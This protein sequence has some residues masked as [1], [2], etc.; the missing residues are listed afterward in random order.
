MLY[1][2]WGAYK[3]F[4]LYHLALH[5]ATGRDWLGWK[6]PEPRR[7]LYVD[8]EMSLYTIRLRFHQIARG[9][10][11]EVG[12]WGDKLMVLPRVG[13]HVTETAAPTLIRALGKWGF[14]PDVVILE[15][16]R[17]VMLGDENQAGNVAA[18][19]RNIAPLVNQGWSL[20]VSHHMSK[21]SHE[22]PRALRDRQSGS[23][24]ILAG[25][26]CAI[27]VTRQGNSNSVD[28]HPTKQRV[29]KLA[30]TFTVLVESTGDRWTGPVTVRRDATFKRQ[31]ENPWGPS[32]AAPT[33]PSSSAPR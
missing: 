13:F 11:L 1:G 2:E 18:F 33:T 14:T 30:D 8:E 17:R 28:L 23:T 21:P 25:V 22:Y 7:V 4:L 5:L 24:D 9:M 3:S 20:Y 32:T 27:A 10:G 12:E 16:L 15:A 6:I 19:W 26:D 29:G 31:D